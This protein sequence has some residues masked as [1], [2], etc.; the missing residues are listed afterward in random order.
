MGSV[1]LLC[2]NYG[3]AEL[4]LDNAL[5][6]FEDTENDL[7]RA[8]CLESLGDLKRCK[9]LEKEAHAKWTASLE[10][11]ESFGETSSIVRVHEKLALAHTA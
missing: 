10:I 5:L 8:W 4:H 2:G 6:T 3:S 11:Y 7:G 9:G 1:E